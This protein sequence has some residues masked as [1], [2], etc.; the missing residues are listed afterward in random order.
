MTL[1]EKQ[2]R[3]EAA[4]RSHGFDVP[5]IRSVATRRDGK[6]RRS[7]PKID[8][9]DRDAVAGLIVLRLARMN[10]G[11]HRMQNPFAFSDIDVDGSPDITPVMM[12]RMRSSFSFDEAV[13]ADLDLMSMLLLVEQVALK[14]SEVA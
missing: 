10:V 8:W 13:T 1:L 7:D 2:Q 14:N 12:V 4:V 3:V 11:I 9:S 6:I 5:K